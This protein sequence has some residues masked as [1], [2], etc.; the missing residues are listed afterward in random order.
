MQD[1]DE[2]SAERD[3]GKRRSVCVRGENQ[4]QRGCGG[5]D[6]EGPGEVSMRLLIRLSSTR[7]SSCHHLPS[8][9]RINRRLDFLTR[10]GNECF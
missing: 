6:G 7:L 1:R 5:R 2:G 3:Y 4:P 8:S 10:S 9:V